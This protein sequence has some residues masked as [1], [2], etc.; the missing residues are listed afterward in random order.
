MS[1]HIQSTS[2]PTDVSARPAVSCN[3]SLRY[4]IFPEKTLLHLHL[5]G[6][7]LPTGS[8]TDWVAP[9][10]RQFRQGKAD[11]LCMAKMEGKGR[12]YPGSP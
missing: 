2:S 4:P 5:Y 12:C 7:D 8:P 10:R 3:M 1:A 9:C 6:K 11:R